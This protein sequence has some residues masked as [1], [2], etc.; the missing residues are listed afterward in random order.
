MQSVSIIYIRTRKLEAQ[1]Q[2]LY[3]VSNAQKDFSTVIRAGG[4]PALGILG[5]KAGVVSPTRS[6]L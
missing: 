1:R 5:S 2:I 3:A 6:G 4:P